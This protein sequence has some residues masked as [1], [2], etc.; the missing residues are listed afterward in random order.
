LKKHIF[1]GKR[2]YYLALFFVV[3]V[4]GL[5]PIIMSRFYD[6]YSASVLTAIGTG[7]SLLLLLVYNAR[8]L[9][10]LTARYFMIAAPISA[11]NSAAC[12]LQKIGLQYTTPA[13]YAFLEHLSCVVVPLML[14]ILVKKRPTLPQAISAVLCLGGCFILCGVGTA[15]AT[16]L[17]F[18]DILCALAGVMLGVC[19]ALTGVFGKGLDMSLYMLV[20]MGVYFI[21]SVCSTIALNF[22]PLGGTVAEPILFTF[23]LG[24][25]VLAALFGLLSIGLCWLLK[26]T[27]TVRLDPTTVAVISP[28]AAVISAIASVLVGEDTLHY[29]LVIGGVLILVAVLFSDIKVPTRRREG[30]PNS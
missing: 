14:F 10:D 1:V 17:A 7:A 18:G 3:L 16:S 8:R 6:H 28:F 24:L 22:I 26:N 5:D 21:I 30:P 4:W 11:L 29:N 27:A 9:R 20:H 23:D 12:L 15:G 25:L 13:N 2:P 19:V